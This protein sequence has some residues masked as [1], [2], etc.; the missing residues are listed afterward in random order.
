MDR[1]DQAWA[2]F[3]CSLLS[4]LLLG[5]IPEAEREAY[6][7]SLAEEERLLP[8]GQRKRISVR[9]F[10]RWWKRLREEGV[11]GAFR[12]RRSDRGQPQSKQ[13]PLLNRAVE[14]KKEQPHRSDVVINRILRKEFGRGVARSTLYRHLRRQGATKRKLGISR[15]PV[16]C[17]WTRDLPGALW[18]GDFEHGPPVIH[19]ERAVKTHLSAWIDCHSRYVVEARYYIRENLDVLIDSLLR[20]WSHHGASR[21]LYVDNAKIYHANA[22]KLACTQL[23][24]KLLH[25]PPRDPAAGG[26][27]ERFFQTIQEQLEAE[28]RAA[29][30]LSLGDINRVLQAWLSQEYHQAVHSQTR[31]TPHQR[32]QTASRIK[33][34]VRMQSVVELFYRR[35]QRT[36]D[37]DHSDVTIDGQHFAVDLKLRG[38]RLEVRYDP[39]QTSPQLQEVQLYGLDGV[40]LG[41][42]RLYQREKG[43][44]PQPDPSTAPAETIE[45]AYLEAL[46]ESHQASQQQRRQTGLDFHSARDRNVWSLSSFATLMARLLGREGGLSSL[47][48]D[49]LDALRGFHARHDRVHESL[50]RDAV[51]QAE[52]LTIP[53]VLWQLQSLL[54]Q[55]DS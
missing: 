55:G 49:E 48:V 2:V 20:A 40:Y 33:R 43:Y 32:Y 14:L 4:P 26:L 34:S 9:T 50:L 46:L 15:K 13:Q 1:N 23:N 37:D 36:V 19:Q 10:R 28:I 24:I 8:N 22:L 6:F 53:H 27:I 54:S 35:L 17:R 52:A 31:Q 42:G 12:R 5:E 30:L 7:R 16:R 38:D 45:P 47:S 29:Q 18:V 39:F 41:V 25:R 51:A 11:E 21:E 3:W 44:H